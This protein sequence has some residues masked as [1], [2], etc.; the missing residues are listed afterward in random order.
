[1]KN[2]QAT[3][4]ALELLKKK[5]IEISNLRAEINILRRKLD[6]SMGVK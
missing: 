6:E 5:D 2:N 3:R 4:D 1:M